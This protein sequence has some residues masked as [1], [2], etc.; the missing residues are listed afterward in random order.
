MYE[1]TLGR[2][3]ETVQG[4]LI[5]CQEA[6]SIQPCGAGIDTRTLKAGEL[7]FAFKGEKTD[8]HDYLQQAREKGAAGA[9]IS[10]LPEGFN[11]D[12]FP[13]IIVKDVKKAIQQTALA[14]R[15]IF[16]GPVIAVTGSTGKTSTKDMVWSILSEKDPVLRNIGNYNNELGLPLTLLAL[17]KNHWAVVLEMGMRGLGEI[18][19]LACLSEP[20]YGIIT[21]VGYTH[22]ELLGSRE[23]IAQA[24][25]ELLSHIPYSGAIFL[26]KEDK[27]LLK[28]WLSNIRSKVYWISRETKADIW[29]RDIREM[30][31]QDGQPSI[32]FSVYAHTGKECSVNMPVPGKH[33][34]SNALLA[35]GISRQLGLGW[36][37][38]IAGLQKL[39]FTSMRLEL[40]NIAERNILLIND[41]YNANPSSMIA[42]LEVLK[43]RTAAG[44]RAIAVL[45]DMYELGD[46]EEKGHRLVGNKAK[47]IEPAYLITVGNKARFIA[48][49]AQ[50]AGMDKE[51]IQVCINNLEA[52]EV[53]KRIIQPEDVILIKGSRGMKMEVI[54]NGLLS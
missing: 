5:S 40:Q 22:M 14:M 11:S 16:T 33:N 9:V 28:P 1:L 21:N 7:F 36:E 35:A 50:Q 8:G 53:L 2:I 45:G 26:N 24:K 3:A 47:D 20:N 10:Y 12:G 46:Y 34:V 43:S 30:W 25:A 32:A 39:R 49:G 19:F 15:R 6:E 27:M 23:H 41:A 4:E 37:A 52:L 48:E 13:V 29:A 51:R 38:V 42:A 44:R 17:E 18:D 31:S 54:A